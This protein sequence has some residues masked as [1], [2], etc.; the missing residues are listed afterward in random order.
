M[1]KSYCFYNL[2]FCNI[3]TQK[4]ILNSKLTSKKL[5]PI[6]IC[7]KIKSRG[8][9]KS[10]QE[11]IYLYI[12]FT[13]LWIPKVKLKLVTTSQVASSGPTVSLDWW[14]YEVIF[15]RLRGRVISW[16]RKSKYGSHLCTWPNW[17]VT[18][19]GHT[20]WMYHLLRQENI[21]FLFHKYM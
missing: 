2:A 21:C 3:C 5:L 18:I 7:V 19:R 6:H 13:I 1:Y 8:L 16:L 14:L 15:I 20:A 12:F 17:I 9:F 4:E 11:D 10:N